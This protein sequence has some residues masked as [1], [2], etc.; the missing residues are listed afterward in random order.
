MKKSFKLRKIVMKNAAT[1]CFFF[2]CVQFSLAQIQSGEIIYKVRPPKSLEVY[3]DT[4][5][6]ETSSRVKMFFVRR[7]RNIKNTAQHL[8]FSLLFNKNES[9]FQKEPGMANDNGMDIEKAARATGVYGLYYV[10][11]EENLSLNQYSSPLLGKL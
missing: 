2:C 3:T 5:K 11:N 8:R 1:L 7:Y 9:R 4:S 10:N 6:M